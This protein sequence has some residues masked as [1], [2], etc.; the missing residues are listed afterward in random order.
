MSGEEVW[1]SGLKPS[2]PLE[3]R[4]AGSG[5]PC[6]LIKSHQIQALV[7]SKPKWDIEA[8]KQVDR[9]NT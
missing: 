1:A 7:I 8:S 9:F 6:N 4:K 3:N 5:N 2:E